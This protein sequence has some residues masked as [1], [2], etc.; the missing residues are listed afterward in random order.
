LNLAAFREPAPNNRAARQK[1]NAPQRW[2]ARTGRNT[3]QVSTRM[4]ALANEAR[5]LA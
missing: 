2:Q 4:F 1:E 5:K 3:Y